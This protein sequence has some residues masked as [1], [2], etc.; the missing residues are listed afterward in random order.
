MKIKRYAT[1]IAAASFSVS[2]MAAVVLS[3]NFDDVGALAAA[4][5]VQVNNS[6]VVGGAYFQGNSGIF[7]SAAGALDSYKLAL[8]CAAL[9]VPR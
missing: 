3:E 7:P 5:W 2:S 1:A 9:R 6:T 8:I 4:G